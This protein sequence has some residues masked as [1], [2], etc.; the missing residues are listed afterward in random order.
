MATFVI[1][2]QGLYFVAARWRDIA[3]GE[4]YTKNTGLRFYGHLLKLEFVLIYLG[5]KICFIHLLYRYR[6]FYKLQYVFVQCQHKSY[7]STIGRSATLSDSG[8]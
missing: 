2:I 4:R 6:S 1:K 7:V 3:V 5:I 8:T